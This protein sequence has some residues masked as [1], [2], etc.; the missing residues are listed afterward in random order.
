ALRGANRGSTDHSSF[1]RKALLVVQATLSVVLVSGSTMLARSLANLEGQDFGFR[2]PDRVLV[3]LNRLPETYTAARL[4]ALYRELGAR[5]AA[6]AGMQGAG[7][8]LYNPVTDNWGE[9]VLVA[10]HPAPKPNEKIGSSW[11]RVST[12]YAQDLGMP[13]VRGRYFSVADTAMTENVAVV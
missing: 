8:A 6:M 7:L 11:D 12:T 4:A 2:V 9:G 5:L 3:Q 1:A 10:G 13:L